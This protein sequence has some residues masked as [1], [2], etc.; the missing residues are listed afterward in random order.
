MKTWIR[1]IEF[2]KIKYNAFLTLCVI[3][4]GVVQ[5]LHSH[6]TK[7]VLRPETQKIILIGKFATRG[8]G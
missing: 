6:F 7:G 1:L 5:L 8:R 3:Y 2:F 4:L